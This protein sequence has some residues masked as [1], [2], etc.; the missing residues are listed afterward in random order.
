MGILTL[1]KKSFGL[2]EEKETEPSYEEGE[3][4]L[5]KELSVMDE[6]DSEEKTESFDWMKE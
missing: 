3:E 1:L 4:E 6:Q 2:I 5:S